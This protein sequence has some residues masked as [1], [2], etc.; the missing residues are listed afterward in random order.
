MSSIGLMMSFA[1]SSAFAAEPCGLVGAEKIDFSQITA[2]ALR[3]VEANVEIVPADTFEVRDGA[4][5]CSGKDAGVVVR[6]IRKGSVLLVRVDGENSSDAK[7]TFSVPRTLEAVSTDHHVG[8]L[9]VRDLPARI[10]VVS[11]TGLVEVHGAKSLRVAYGTGDVVADRVAT[12]VTVDNL[13]GNLT[14]DDVAGA[15]A[16]SAV[17]GTV[18]HDNVRGAVSAL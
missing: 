12:D 1:M 13:A 17:S 5:V 10:A 11:N 7:L 18:V 14:V 6:V 16:T 3:G 9:V 15:L 8:A 4:A 2:M